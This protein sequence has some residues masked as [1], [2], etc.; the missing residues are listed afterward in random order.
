MQIVDYLKSLNDNNTVWNDAD[1][2]SNVPFA[3]IP[4]HSLATYLLIPTCM[5]VG[6]VS[7][8]FETNTHIAT[9]IINQYSTYFGTEF[10]NIYLK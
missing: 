10:L 3:E 9:R 8:L 4:L 1:P 2:M 5:N 6:K 7:E